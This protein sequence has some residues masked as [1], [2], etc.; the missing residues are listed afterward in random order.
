LGIGHHQA[1][2]EHLVFVLTFVPQKTPGDLRPCGDCPTLNCTTPIPNSGFL[3]SLHGSHILSKFD[4][5]CAYHQIPI[6]PADMPKTAVTTPFGLF[7]FLRMP[8][9][10]V[11]LHLLMPRR[12]TKV[13]TE[14]ADQA[15]QS[16]FQWYG[17]EAVE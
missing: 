17:N 11:I 3:I 7:E 12:G 13:V 15:N 5:I 6:K 2:I 16:S 1:I 10:G 9:A 4:L 8:Y 14:V